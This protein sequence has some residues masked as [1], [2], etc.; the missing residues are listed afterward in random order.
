MGRFNVLLGVVIV[1]LAIMLTRG[2]PI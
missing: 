2:P 1:A